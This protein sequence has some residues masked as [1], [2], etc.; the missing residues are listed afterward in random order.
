MFAADLT[1]V[2]QCKNSWLDEHRSKTFKPEFSR[3]DARTQVGLL[4]SNDHWI[5]T[6]PRA[7]LDG[8]TPGFG[9]SAF[10][11]SSHHSLLCRLGPRGKD[12]GSLVV[13]ERLDHDEWIVSD[14]L[15]AKPTD[16]LFSISDACGVC[17]NL[18]LIYKLRSP[19][20]R[21]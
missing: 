17:M 18:H 21:T 9:V 12:A 3:F 1:F 15:K 19:I 7:S 10:A 8:Q 14:R 20:C 4:F 5:Q 16:S 11:S 2:C 13:A 6:T